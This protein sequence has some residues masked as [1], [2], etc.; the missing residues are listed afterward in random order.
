MDRFIER[1]FERFQLTVT[2]IL[3]AWNVRVA[4]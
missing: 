2:A 1:D 3:I 4:G